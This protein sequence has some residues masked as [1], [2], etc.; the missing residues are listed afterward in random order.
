[1]RR[2]LAATAI[3]TVSL[4]GAATAWA[5]AGDRGP[6]AADGP[7]LSVS[8]LEAAPGATVTVEGGGCGTEEGAGAWTA[9][10]WLI[11]APGTVTWDPSFGEPVA[12]ITPDENGGW[13]T[14]LTVPEH[15]TE[16]RLEAAC[17]D[18]AS[19]PGGFVYAHLR[20]VAR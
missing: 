8:T 20:F 9:Q 7:E 13:S 12:E 2:A 18:E 1:M 17:L 6:S 19:P 11:P 15:R 3:A 4:A 5:V 16:Y 10:V 14:T